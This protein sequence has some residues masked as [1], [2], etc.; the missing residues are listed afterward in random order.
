MIGT[1]ASRALL[2]V[3]GCVLLASCGT[4]KPST[5]PAGANPAATSSVATPAASSVATPA[6]SSEAA[7]PAAAAAAVNA[8]GSGMTACGLITEQDAS[9]A[10]GT[11]A[12]HGTAGGTAALSECIYAQGALIVSMK[13][14]SKAL[15]DRSR[16]A[17]LGKGASNVPGIGDSAFKSG[18]DKFCSM[19]FVK[20]TTLVS[21]LVGETGAQNVAVA[22]AKIAAS[23]L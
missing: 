1:P 8:G 20:G 15:Y 12:G 19:L 23:K 2:T 11:A 14:D 22:V 6:A 4:A 7:T 16:I 17:A 13:T 9:A 10:L 18:T 5:A 3:V 21:I